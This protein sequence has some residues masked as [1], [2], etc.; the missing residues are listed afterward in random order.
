MQ[1]LPITCF[2]ATGS[3]APD[4]E[5]LFEFD[6]VL[7]GDPK[8]SGFVTNIDPSG[9]FV[10]GIWA[11][12]PGKYKVDPYH[13]NCF[14]FAHILE[15]KVKITDSE[16]NIGTYQAGDTIVTQKGFKGTWDVIEPIRKV[17]A[18]LNF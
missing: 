7:S 6:E 5:P 18:T 16:G 4:L 12:Q 15:G 10:T 3:E 2:Q 17:F 9:K 14:E 11:C 13:A 8:Q 1:T